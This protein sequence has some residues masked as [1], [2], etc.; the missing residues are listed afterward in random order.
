MI[1]RF[2]YTFRYMDVVIK[3][4]LIN[5]CLEQVKGRANEITLALQQAQEAIENETKSSAGDKYETSREML[6]QDINRYHGQ[7]L[8]IKKDWSILHKLETRV[9]QYAEVG[10]I[11]VT[12]QA[13]YFIAVSLGMQKLNNRTFVVVSPLSPIG[14]LL[15][16]AKEGD[17]IRFNDNEQIVTGLY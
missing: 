15:I 10:S 17:T 5:H 9:R 2:F 6:Q 14:K 3:K 13:T 1:G 16:G 7:L 12:G 8:Q 11:V 4:Q